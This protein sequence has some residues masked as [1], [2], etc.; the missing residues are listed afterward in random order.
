M[1][2]TESEFADLVDEAIQTL[3][4]DFRKHLR[5]LTVIVQARP[6]E[7]LLRAIDM[8]GKML[9]GLYQGIPVTRKS[10]RRPVELPERILIFQENIEA[11]CR[12]EEDVIQRVRKVV[13]HEVGH[14]FGFG[15]EELRRLGYR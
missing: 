5:N 7:Q 12:S 2:F 14:H 10:V 6:D 3:P 9:L 4:S 13:L 1:R 11:V 15:E 8:E